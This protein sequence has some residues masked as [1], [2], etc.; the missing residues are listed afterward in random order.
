MDPNRTENEGLWDWNLVSNRIHFSPR[1]IALVGCDAHEIGGT[2]ETWLQRVHPEDRS[3]V[4]CAI[5]THLADGSSDFDIRHRMLHADGSCRWMSCRAAIERNAEGQATRVTGAHTDVTAATVTDPQTGLPNHLLLAEHLTRS[6]E[7]ATHYPGF[8]YAVLL[9]DLDRSATGDASVGS[10]VTNA[11]LAAAARRLE[12]SLRV[13]HVPPMLRHSDLVARLEGNR[14]AILLDGLKELDHAVIVAERILEEILAPFA[15]GHREVF[16]SASLGIAVSAT[17][18][19]RG[20]DALRDAETALHRAKQLG[21]SRCEVFDTAILRSLQ[22][23]LQLE[24]D[25]KPAL[26][27]QEFHV[28]YQPIVSLESNN[29]VGFEALVRWQHPVLGMIPPVEFI[30]IA[31]RTGLIVP[32]G[33]WVLREACLQL[34][35]WQDS[36]SAKDLWI[37]VNVS[38]VQL[39]P[40]LIEDIGQ[41]LRDSGVEARCLV[42]ELTESVAMENP[43]AATTLLMQIRALGVRVSLDDFGTGHSSLAY[44]RQLPVDA[45]KIDQS[46]VRG[47]ETNDD[48]TGIFGI[49]TTTAQQLG[50]SVVAE[51]IENEEQLALIRRLRCEFGQGYLL[52]R[53]VDREAASQILKTGLPSCE[54]RAA[55]NR[56][57]TLRPG[58]ADEKPMGVAGRPS[59]ARI[60]YMAAAVLT[61]MVS[62]GFA[63]RLAREPQAEARPVMLQA[64]KVAPAASVVAPSSAAIAPSAPVV[65]PP[66]PAVAP[67]APSVAPPVRT[68][69]LPTRGEPIRETRAPATVQPVVSETSFAAVHQHRFGSCRGMLVVSRDGVTFLPDEGKEKGNDAFSF[70]HSEF[71]HELEDDTL[72]I[73]SRDRTYRFKAALAVDRDDNE[74]KLKQLANSIALLR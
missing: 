44:L 10:T 70:R 6:I 1:W 63:S 17:G 25:L 8:H 33:R 46:F 65:V 22:T 38:S 43:T 16:L 52:S 60:L 19:S 28:F 3:L 71:L 45:L 36:Q 11:L 48:M 41:A 68:A 4:T 9:L 69:P 57:A 20:D 31:E 37:S 53:P 66:A 14:F 47:I 54:G 40:A 30:A 55:E 59:T 56:T 29:V 18:Y 73:T 24:A 72:T 61:V 74:N 34:K 67:P 35:T 26:E 21:G 62:I 51:G 23:A 50:L 49:V 2:Q 13:W 58:P 5:E 7:R 42:L 39:R 32:L 15:M 27:R 12:T 64:E